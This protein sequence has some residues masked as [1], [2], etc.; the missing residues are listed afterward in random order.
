[1]VKKLFPSSHDDIGKLSNGAGSE[2]IYA[3]SVT[4]VTNT[5]LMKLT[6]Q[7]F[8]YKGKEKESS[9]EERTAAIQKW[10]DWWQ[11]NKNKMQK[12]K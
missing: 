2:K 9:K 5:V 4:D 6:G 1:M 12:D 10:L 3:Y 7:D 8:G 11:T